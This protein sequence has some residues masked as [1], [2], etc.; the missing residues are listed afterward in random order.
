MKINL[1]LDQ[2]YISGNSKTN[3]LYISLKNQGIIFKNNIKSALLASKIILSYKGKKK[4]LKVS[5]IFFSIMISPVLGFSKRIYMS[6]SNAN[7]FLFGRSN[8]IKIFKNDKIINKINDNKFSRRDDF[9]RKKINLHFISPTVYEFTDNY[10]IEE[11][12]EKYSYVKDSSRAKKQLIA[13]KKLF[14][15]IF[16]N[17]EK[18]FQK[19][20]NEIRAMD[21]S[22][23]KK[24]NKIKC[25][26]S[27]NLKIT[28]SHGDFTNK[29]IFL[30]HNNDT[31]LIDF[32]FSA[33]RSDTYD[34]LFSLY[35]TNQKYFMKNNLNFNHY[36]FLLERLCL[37]V[38]IQLHLE[39]SY[40]EE[41]DCICLNLRQQL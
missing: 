4:Y 41:I 6:S 32:E 3:H 22:I 12:I 35:Y 37:I 34:E 24:I 30:L 11:L 13:F 9:I 27:G 31:L 16:I 36:I 33:Y 23:Y 1:N 28:M 14:K 21:F 17:K 5:L 20:I 8:K 15:T 7:L 25:N 2:K 10:Y 19:K 38:K 26:D 18:Y 29:N 40:E 39:K